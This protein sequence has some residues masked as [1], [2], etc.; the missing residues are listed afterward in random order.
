MRTAHLVEHAAAA[1]DRGALVAHRCEC[2]CQSRL[3]LVEAARGAGALV[4]LALDAGDLV[5]GDEPADL[6]REPRRTQRIKLARERFDARLE[7][8]EFVAERAR[9]RLDRGQTLRLR[10]ALAVEAIRLLADEI[11]G[12]LR[13]ERLLL[14]FLSPRAL[15]RRD[16]LEFR[17]RG[18]CVLKIGGG[19]LG[20]RGKRGCVCLERGDLRAL[21]GERLLRLGERAL[22]EVRALLRLRLDARELE[23]TLLEAVLLVLERMAHDL[24]ILLRVL[25]G[26]KRRRKR[27]LLAFEHLQFA[28][29]AVQA[30]LELVEEIEREFAA[31][32]SLARIELLEPPCLVGL[33]AHDAQAPLG[34]GKLLA[35]GDEVLLGALELA[36]RLDLP[37]AEAGH[38]CGLLEDRAPLDRIREQHRVDLALLDDR[39]GVVADAR[40]EEK[41]ADVL[42][43][44]LAGV[45]EVVALA[46]G[47]EAA[48][49]LDEIGV[50]RKPA[51]ANRLAIN[52]AFDRL[53]C[54]GIDLVVEERRVV[55]APLDRLRE[56]RVLEAERHARHA[57]GLARGAACKDD[58]EHGAAAKALRAAFAEHP[59]DGVDD[60]RLAAAVGTHDA[61]DGGIETELRG[62]RKALETAQ[63]QLGKP[64]RN[65]TSVSHAPERRRSHPSRKPA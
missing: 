6:M 32:E 2:G 29:Q 25:C 56:E 13:L 24:G 44:D 27:G 28:R 4:E 14:G 26:R 16:L 20:F 60:I 35:R 42:E 45:D 38:A 47:S 49:D 15:A 59:L 48:G 5:V 41:V 62:I 37:H 65:S 12:A 39:V 57:R 30:A 55:P 43:T 10:A 63:N 50:D 17:G 58:I 19:L 33:P 11:G 36:R 54:L 18:R 7:A 9:A 52:D 3:R 40:V 21:D 46:V 51:V 8:A 61:R 34:V 53:A 64:H 22:R 23:P 31:Q 1:L